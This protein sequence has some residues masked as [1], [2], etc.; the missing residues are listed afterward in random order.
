MTRIERPTATIAFLVPRRRAMRRWRSP[1]KVS[2][3]PAATA[4]SPSTRA[5]YGL[6]CPVVAL[7]LALPAD[8]L[9]PGA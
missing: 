2:V 4:A 1:K 5:R 8:W 9:T 7:P 3:R 6:P